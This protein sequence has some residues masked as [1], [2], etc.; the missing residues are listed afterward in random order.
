[1][2]GPSNLHEKFMARFNELVAEGMALAEVGDQPCHR[3]YTA[4]KTKCE[5]ILGE[6]LTRDNQITK[7]FRQRKCPLSYAIQKELGILEGVKDDFARGFLRGAP[8]RTKRKQAK[9]DHQ[10]EVLA[11]CLRRCCVCFALDHENSQKAGQIA[12][13][14]HDPS[15]DDPDNLVFLCL[16]HHDQYD[17]KTSQSKNLTEA[18]V[19]KYR[20]VLWHAVE[21]GL[22]ESA[23]PGKD[24]N[25][26]TQTVV[27]HNSIINPTQVNVIYRG[28][29]RGGLP[30]IP[31]GAIATDLHKRNYIL[32]LI[33]RYI[34]YTAKDKTH[35]P[36]RPVIYDR[37]EKEFGA[38][39]DMVPLSRFEELAEYLKS[40][41]DKTII[42]KRNNR[43]GHKN[44]SPFE[45][46]R[47]QHE[48]QG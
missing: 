5:T 32:H 11:R 43:L 6:V 16:P 17:S 18:E 47:W 4:W 19:R 48:P 46:P 2:S 45:D 44:Y 38:K 20:S 8:V 15:N 14:D 40:R 23:P 27:G 36:F 9:P 3:R 29:S 42:G 28:K 34:V 21:S 7:D 12:H 24:S 10:A 37:I 30:V 26:F 22:L 13:L 1:M 41:I 35:K 25:T 39:W 31:P 33:K